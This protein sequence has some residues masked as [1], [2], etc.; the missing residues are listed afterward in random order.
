MEKVQKSLLVSPSFC[1]YNGDMV[2]TFK[3]P[4]FYRGNPEHLQ[5]RI[6]TVLFLFLSLSIILNLTHLLVFPADEEK[7]LKGEI[8]KNLGTSS[9]H[10]KLAQH[11]LKTN[12]LEAEREYRLAEELYQTSQSSSVNPLGIQSS[13]LE[14]WQALISTREKLE[15]EK[16]YW[17]E[18]NKNFPDY[19]Y[20]NLK[21]AQISWEL[22]DKNLAKKYLSQ[23]LETSPVEETAN[24]FWEKFK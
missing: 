11:Y 16:K 3:F 8:M 18:I 10:E 17:Q 20:A 14:T 19:Q 23:V 15:E 9:L 12:L 22:G 4:H 7:K 13:P 5:K 24:L 1:L 6:K 21:L 2:M